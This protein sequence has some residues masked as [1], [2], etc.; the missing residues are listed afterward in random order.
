MS[1]A[2]TEL[3]AEM[4]DA[5]IK[6]TA[7]SAGSIPEDMRMSQAKD[8]KGHPLWFLGHMTFALNQI[9]HIFALGKEAVVPVEYAKSFQ[10]KEA[11][12]GPITGNAADYPGWD[13]VLANYKKAGEACVAG[14]KAL[15]DDELSGDLRGEVPEALKS[16]FGNLE[17]TIGSMIGHDAYHRGQMTL[18]ASLNK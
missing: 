9:V 5:T 7:T 1:N 3:Y 4:L 15:Q 16:F 6:A 10:P 11:G 17:G 18:L 12:G 13:E 2:R 8:G 14:I